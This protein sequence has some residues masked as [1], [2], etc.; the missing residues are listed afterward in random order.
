MRPFLLFHQI[1]RDKIVRTRDPEKLSR[2]EYVCDVGGIYDPE[3]KR[4]DHHQSDYRGDLSSAGM[5]WEY[6]KKSGVIDE[7]TYDY[8]NHSLIRGV[9]AIDNGRDFLEVGHCTF[10]QVVSNFVPPA[11]DAAPRELG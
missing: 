3:R 8:F 11:Y 9:D 6:F 10:S 4:F 7:P 5:I 1:D 2:C